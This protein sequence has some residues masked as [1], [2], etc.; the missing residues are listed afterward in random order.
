MGHP[1][2]QKSQRIPYR[3]HILDPVVCAAH[4]DQEYIRQNDISIPNNLRIF[5]EADFRCGFRCG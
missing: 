3:V 1:V 2:L 4:K 5:S